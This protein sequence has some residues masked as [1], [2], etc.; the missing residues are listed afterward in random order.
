MRASSRTPS[1]IP[2]GAV[3]EGEAPGCL[4]ATR[5]RSTPRPDPEDQRRIEH[6]R[7]AVDAGGHGPVGV[8]LEAS[9]PST[10]ARGAAAGAASPRPVGA[11][12]TV[13][14]SR[15][16]SIRGRVPEPIALPSR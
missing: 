7:L 14:P 1:H 15:P 2:S 16:S 10:R 11:P 4:R 9:A 6:E 12:M 5:T 8:D 3:A 13:T